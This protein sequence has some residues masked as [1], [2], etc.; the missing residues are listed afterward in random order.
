[1]PSC[2]PN[3]RQVTVS[4]VV[5][6]F[7]VS[8][9]LVAAH[10]AYQERDTSVAEVARD[11]GHQPVQLLHGSVRPVVTKGRGLLLRL[12]HLGRYAEQLPE[13]LAVDEEVEKLDLVLVFAR[14][15]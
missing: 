8:A 2:H 15:P 10:R 9:G 11:E 3:R 5:V 12:R 7:M 4:A 6:S 14:V 13:W 1:M